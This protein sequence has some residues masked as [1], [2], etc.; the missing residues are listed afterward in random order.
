MV[1]D[2]PLYLMILIPVLPR[3][4][5][6]DGILHSCMESYKILKHNFLYKFLWPFLKILRKPYIFF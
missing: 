2:N 4:A 5:K 6:R 1:Q 3:W